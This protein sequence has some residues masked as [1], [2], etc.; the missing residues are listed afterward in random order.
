VAASRSDQPEAIRG[1]Y[2]YMKTFLILSECHDGGLYLQPWGRD[3]K[4]NDPAMGPR[5][6]PTSAGIMMLALSKKR[7]FITGKEALAL[8]NQQ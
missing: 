8:K 1:Y 4:N 3:P 2:D 5:I 6:L 7:L